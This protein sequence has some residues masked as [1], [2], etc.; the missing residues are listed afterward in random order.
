MIKEYFANYFLYMSDFTFD[1][2]KNERKVLRNGVEEWQVSV[3]DT[4]DPTMTGGRLRRVKDLMGK[5]TF[6]LTYGDGVSEVNITELIR[7]HRSQKTLTALT[8]T[9][10][11]GRF[12]TMSLGQQQTKILSFQEKPERDG[13]WINGGSFVLEPGVMDY[14]VHDSTI[15]EREPLERL[16]HPGKLAAYKHEGFWRPLNT[17]RDKMN[18][19][20]LWASG[21]A[22]WKVW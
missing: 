16:A 10:T 15:W 12:G 18:L 4:G 20:Q 7:F 1:L 8:A 14:I 2:K 6:C 19:E 17:L 21:K 11:P 9:Q 5:E 13:A 22:P 3:V